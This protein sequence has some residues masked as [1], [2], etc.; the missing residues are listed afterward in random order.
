MSDEA[1]WVRVFE[2]FEKASEERQAMT[3]EQSQTN[4][5]LDQHV[6]LSSEKVFQVEQKVNKLEDDLDGNGKKGLKLE[7]H[8]VGIQVE[9]VREGMGSIAGELKAIKRRHWAIAILIIGG[10]VTY[11]VNIVS[12]GATP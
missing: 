5:R 11:I 7:V 12:T 3:L 4:A 8:D 9:Q 2:A 6:A 1:K 10:F